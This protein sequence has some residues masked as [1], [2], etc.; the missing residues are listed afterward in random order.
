MEPGF[1]LL[2]V[3]VKNERLDCLSERG[4]GVLLALSYNLRNVNM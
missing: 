3:F 1:Q 4:V 2:Q